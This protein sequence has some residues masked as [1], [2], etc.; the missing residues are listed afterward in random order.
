MQE[1]ISASQANNS[2]AALELFSKAC[3]EEPDSA[4][5][6]FLLGAEL[7]Q[8]GRWPETEE[9]YA[10]AVIAAPLLAIARFELGSLQFTSGRPA[11]ALMTWQPL[12][13]LADT[14]TLKLTTSA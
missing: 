14:D 5:P 6:H 13:N 3:K 9:A 7:A 2:Q 10:N 12:L 8:L 4:W 11:I 1:A